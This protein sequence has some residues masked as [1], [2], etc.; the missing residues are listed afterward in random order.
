MQ[1]KKACSKTPWRLKPHFPETVLLQLK[2][3]ALQNASHIHAKCQSAA[4]L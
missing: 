3:M 4:L 2:P 1:P